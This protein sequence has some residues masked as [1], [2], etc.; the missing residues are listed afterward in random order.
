MLRFLPVGQ[1]TLF[2]AVAQGFS[3]H[4]WG[5]W[6]RRFKSAQPDSCGSCLVSSSLFFVS[7]WNTYDNL[8]NI[9]GNWLFFSQL[10]E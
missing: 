8:P 6:G 10:E 7:I 9:R 5:T 4:V 1:P 3:V 2:R